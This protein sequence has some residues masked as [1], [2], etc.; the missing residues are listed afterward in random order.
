MI[1]E[2]SLRGL[3][4]ALTIE[5][6]GKLIYFVLTCV[7]DIKIWLIITCNLQ[8]KHQ[9]QTKKLP[10]ECAH[11]HVAGSAAVFF[12]SALTEGFLIEVLHY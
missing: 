10:P 3:D 5:Y 11:T 1:R 7:H 4:P 9:F 8:K 6:V 2:R 12:L